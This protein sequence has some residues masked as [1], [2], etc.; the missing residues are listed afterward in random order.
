MDKKRDEPVVLRGVGPDVPEKYHLLR[1]S[2]LRK[3]VQEFDS[4]QVKNGEELLGIINRQAKRI[5]SV[6]RSVGSIEKKSGNIKEVRWETY[7][8]RIQTENLHASLF[9]DY[10]MVQ[11]AIAGKQGFGIKDRPY[12]GFELVLPDG[13]M[14]N[15]WREQS[16]QLVQLNDMGNVI[17]QYRIDDLSDDRVGFFA[18]KYLK[19]VSAIVDFAEKNETN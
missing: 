14:K 4:A 18:D 10:G 16:F 9:T 6:I 15:K 13:S 17:G 8:P 19:A 3:F 11:I 2:N 12:G 7:T 1:L 5:A